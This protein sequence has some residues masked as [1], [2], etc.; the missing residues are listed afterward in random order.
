MSWSIHLKGRL[1][2]FDLDVAFSTDSR[3]VVVVG[4]NGSGKTTIV[5]ALCGATR[6]A[7]SLVRVG[8]THLDD[9]DAGLRTPMA[10]RR[11][12]YVPQ[13]FGLFEHL[14]A[15]QN[16]AF[17]IRGVSVSER[18]ARAQSALERFDAGHLG[19]RLASRL[20]GGEKQRVALARALACEP[21][22]LVLDEPMSALDVVSRRE[23]RG[24][25]AACLMQADLPTLLV[26]H[27]IR[28][29]GSLSA[30]IVVLNRGRIAQIGTPDELRASPV[31]A[32]VEAFFND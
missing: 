17:G 13:G 3:H 11:V 4:P 29:I 15:R 25:L 7:T 27:D 30:A 24:E 20:S 21:R 1:L 8:N 5:R 16:V 28:D 14:T 22:F 9:S 12:G 19:S 18:D 32:F 6:F 26:T 2:D 31:N 23:L 10:S